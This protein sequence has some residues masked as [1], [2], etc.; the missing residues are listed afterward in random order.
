MMSTLAAPVRR[1][2][3][4]AVSGYSACSGYSPYTRVARGQ[5]RRLVERRCTGSGATG[6]AAGQQAPGARC[7]AG[8]A[9]DPSAGSD[10]GPSRS[11]CS[12][13][14]AGPQLNTGRRA[15]YVKT[16]LPKPSSC[17][18][19]CIDEFVFRPAIRCHRPS[20]A[21]QEPARWKPW[22]TN[23]RGRRVPAR[24]ADG[25]AHQYPRAHMGPEAL[26]THGGTRLPGPLLAHHPCGQGSSPLPGCPG[27]LCG[28]R[29]RLGAKSEEGREVCSHKYRARHILP[30]PLF[31]P[32]GGGVPLACGRHS[33]PRPVSTH[34][35]PPRVP[36][37]AQTSMGARS[38]LSG[39][40][41]TWWFAIR[42]AHSLTHPPAL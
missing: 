28:D 26:R 2:V 42:E 12:R 34:A 16:N 10:V 19:R 6:G 32:G 14:F 29:G 40:V 9:A 24:V 13:S 20:W 37:G 7:A 11:C 30:S 31:P 35:R 15:G 21:E 5:G 36:C 25:W 1:T 3:H 41:A 33:H 22:P 8:A 4:A 18:G 38:K 27:L 39:T 17:G 23:A